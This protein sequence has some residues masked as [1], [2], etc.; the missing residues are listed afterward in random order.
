MD[1][2]G[3][4]LL[5]RHDRAFLNNVVTSSLVFEGNGRVQ[6]YAGG[7][8]DWLRQR[9]ATELEKQ[10]KKGKIKKRTRIK[11]AGP[12]KLSYKETRELEQLPRKIEAAEEEQAK[13]FETM[14]DPAFYQEEGDSVALAKER[15]TDLERFLAVAYDRWQELESIKDK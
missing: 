9:S 12:C 11:P 13:L 14:S 15:L 1:Y 7:Y 8:D 3:T 5:V 10:P 4:L 6:E 2:T